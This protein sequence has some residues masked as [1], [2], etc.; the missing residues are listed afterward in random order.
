MSSVCVCGGRGRFICMWGV[1]VCGMCVICVGC[2]CVYVWCVGEWGVWC[3]WVC[4][5]VYVWCVCVCMCGVCGGEV[6]VYMCD[7]CVEYRERNALGHVPLLMW[8]LWGTP[9]TKWT[10]PGGHPGREGVWFCRLQAWVWV[11]VRCVSTTLASMTGEVPASFCLVRVGAREAAWGRMIPLMDDS[12][13]SNPAKMLF[14]ALYGIEPF[15]CKFPDFLA[16]DVVKCCLCTLAFPFPNLCLHFTLT[17]CLSFHCSNLIKWLSPWGAGS[18]RCGCG[19]AALMIPRK[20]GPSERA[21]LA[22]V[23]PA[24]NLSDSSEEAMGQAL[25][26]S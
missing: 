8:S 15:G 13:S 1:C 6:R 17:T 3:V 22:A 19:W 11:W 24:N 14:L 16:S 21:A 18:R 23:K 26:I 20:E 12:L 4:V 25:S 2:V 10:E 7:G 5:G 9:E